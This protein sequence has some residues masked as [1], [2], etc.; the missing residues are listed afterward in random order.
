MLRE[1]WLYPGIQY[2]FVC[3]QLVPEK[4]NEPLEV[5]ICSSPARAATKP[6]RQRLTSRRSSR[7][8]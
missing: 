8:D 1:N 6:P 3:R 7:P 5:P 4:T 2:P